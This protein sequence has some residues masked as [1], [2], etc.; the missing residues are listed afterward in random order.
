LRNDRGQK[1]ADEIALALTGPWRAAHLFVLLQALESF[2]CY[3]A[4]ISMGEAQIARPFSLIHPR[5][6]S[7]PEA[8]VPPGSA[9]PPRRT[10]HAHS[11]NAPAVPTRAHSLRMPGGDLV[12]GHGISAGI[13]QTILA[14]MGTNMSTWPDDKHF[15]SWLGLA[16]Q[17]A[18][19]GGKGRKSRTL[20]TRTRAA[21][22][23]RMAAQSVLRADCACGALYR[24]LQGRLG[25]AQ[26]LVATAHKIA[27]TVYHMLKD[28]VPYQDIGAA[29]YHKR[30]RERA[31]QY[32]QKKAA[33]F[34]YQLSLA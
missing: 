15:C 3:T 4:Q 20:K 23:C 32:L 11:Q 22:A 31:L 1:D 5:F 33:K 2:D 13:A 26:A 24:R 29:E 7:A 12:A 19:S 28:R 9:P 21:H 8:F 25:P 27:R 18:I 14:E 30:F 6:E 10:P 16:P 17:N 34:G